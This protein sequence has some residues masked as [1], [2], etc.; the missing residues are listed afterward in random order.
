MGVRVAVVGCGYMGNYHIK[1]WRK[2]GAEVAAVCDSKMEK[3]SRMGDKFGIPI[4]MTD[5]Q[6]LLTRDDVEIVDITLPHALHMQAAIDSAAAG[7]HV[8]CEKPM[9]TTADEAIRMAEAC[10]QHGVL[11]MIRHNQRFHPARSWVKTLLE[12][13]AV[14]EI[15]HVRSEWIQL[16]QYMIERPWYGMLQRGKGGTLLGLAI[17]HLDLFRYWIGET[18]W[19][20]CE[21]RNVMIGRYGMDAEDT[22]SL[23]WSFANGASGELFAT[24]A[25]AFPEMQKETIEIYGTEGVIQINNDELIVMSEKKYGDRE[26]HQVRDFPAGEN[27]FEHM[28]RCVQDGSRPLT[29][30]EEI[31]RT[32]KL[33][34]GAY[35]SSSSGRRIVLNGGEVLENDCSR[36]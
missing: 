3:A 1:S 25:A 11:L 34:D 13:R 29:H 17:H 28:I 12:E 30:G 14:G 35:E 18:S 33:V 5:Y 4:R 19:I 10:R 24:N 27:E 21:N 2:A 32:M 9:A 7:K 36:R 31:I 23:Q 16:P 6:A 15:I 26:P 20:S 8:F 22:V